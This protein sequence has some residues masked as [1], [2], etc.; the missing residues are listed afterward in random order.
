MLKN[1]GQ[2]S[3]FIVIGIIILIVS[4]F[5]FVNSNTDIFVSFESQ[6]KNDIDEAVKTC[7]EDSADSGVFMLGFQGGYINIDSRFIPPNSPD[8]LDLGGIYIPNWDSEDG[9][10]PTI[11]SMKGEL[12]E[13]I[14]NNS[15]GCI[16]NRLR[17]L[18]D[19]Y[20]IEFVEELDIDSQINKESVSIEVNFPVRYSEKNS[21]KKSIIED[22]YVSLDSVPLGDL[23][24]LAVEIYNLEEGDYFLEELTLDQ[25]YSASDY[26]NPKSSM[27]SEGIDFRCGQVPWTIF[28]LKQNLINLNNHNFK[29]LYIDGTYPKDDVFDANLNEEFGT[30]GLREYYESSITGYT[31][32]LRNPKRSFSN[33]RADFMLP[34]PYGLER[35]TFGMKDI[36][37][38]FEVSPSDGNIVKPIKIE[39][40]GSSKIPIPCIQTYHHL[41]TLDYDI[42]ARLEDKSDDG[43]GYVFQF[44]LRVNIEKNNPKESVPSYITN[45]RPDRAN[46]DV[47]CSNESRIYPMKVYVEDEE[48]NTLEGVNIS[49]RC[50]SYQCDMGSTEKP[51]YGFNP[52]LVRENS[53]SRLETNFP[54]CVGG[55][56][57]AN[58]PG[59]HEAKVRA[60]TT[61]T[62]NEVEDASGC[63][64]CVDIEMLR[65]KEYDITR[66]TFFAKSIDGSG[67][68]WIY[69]EDDGFVFMTLSN[70]KYGFESEVIVPVYEGY[71]DK[72][73]LLAGNE[74]YYNVT[75]LYADKDY[76]LRGMLEIE[77]WNPQ[78]QRGNN[79]EVVI[80]KSS[81]PIDEDNFMDYHTRS[82]K[83]VSNPMSG[84]GITI[85]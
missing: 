83:L 63:P 29:Y 61:M 41:Y 22:Y 43:T 36:F 62:E 34:V 15:L 82:Q 7:I 59:Y 26:S 19:M 10:I 65:V 12:D 55:T 85:I 31:Q 8:H 13:Y 28:Q 84:Y 52:N 74:Y 33:Y 42:L 46:N 80:P 66:N 70:E 71:M 18:N 57:I 45:L 3:M 68:N 27:P 60:D 40:A 53:E 78:M 37:R 24:D 35:S 58:K 67:S 21:E 16:K 51:R 11:E 25:I 50:I 47:Y 9:N 14:H 20:D 39:V 54:F 56:I 17:D 49:Y 32:Q 73:K 81:A 1:K 5:L 79:L 4:I 30:Y 44:P 76:N 69:D 48:G 6:M 64:E 2:V 38:E 23:Y 72:L 77:N 75:V